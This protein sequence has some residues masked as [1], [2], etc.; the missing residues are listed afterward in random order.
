MMRTHELAS[1]HS[2][3]Q[4]QEYNTFH[5]VK[6]G[7]SLPPQQTITQIC[8][9]NPNS[10]LCDKA[11]NRYLGCVISTINGQHLCVYTKTQ[12]KNVPGAI[13][14]L[15]FTP[16]MLLLELGDE[17]HR[18]C[19]D[20]NVTNRLYHRPMRPQT[21]INTQYGCFHECWQFMFTL[22]GYSANRMNERICI[23]SAKHR[24]QKF[25][26]LQP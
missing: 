1:Q 2:Q 21:S 17:S 19:Y 13:V 16:H 18:N 11:M 12:S 6:G 8:S 5:I 4:V 26:A 14:L 15:M 24:H 22:T 9:H 7:N 3:H 20:S 25:K 10:C 23:V